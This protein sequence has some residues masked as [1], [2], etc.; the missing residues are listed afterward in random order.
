MAGL[1]THVLD[2][3]HGQPADNIKIDLYFLESKEWRLVKTAVTNKDGRLE[4]PLLSDDDVKIGTFE[5]VYHI[6]DYFQSKNIEIPSPAFLDQVPVRFGIANP[7]SHYHVPLLIS[8]WG[9][10]IYRGS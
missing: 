2:L 3:T 9:Y 7:E 10:Q 6:G 5:L 4:H 1:T 8:P